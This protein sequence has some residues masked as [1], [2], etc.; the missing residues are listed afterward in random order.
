[1]KCLLR[2]MI[3]GQRWIAILAVS[4]VLLPAGA[5]RAQQVIGAAQS[6]F[7]SVIY[8][9]A[10]TDL[11]GG[12]AWN[13]AD[14]SRQTAVMQGNAALDLQVATALFDVSRLQWVITRDRMWMGGVNYTLYPDTNA[15]PDPT[16]AQFKTVACTVNGVAA[17]YDSAAN[18]L[19]AV[20]CDLE[21]NAA[22]AQSV[23]NEV[24][25]ISSATASAAFNA[26]IV[27]ARTAAAKLLTD[28][29]K[30]EAAV[31]PAGTALAN[32]GALMLTSLYYLADAQYNSGA[33]GCSVSLPA[34][35]K[36]GAASQRIYCGH[37]I[38][39]LAQEFVFNGN[40]T[41]L[42]TEDRVFNIIQNE[43]FEN[44]YL[45]TVENECLIAKSTETPGASWTYLLEPSDKT[46]YRFGT[47]D[48][49]TAYA[50]TAEAAPELFLIYTAEFIHRSWAST[51]EAAFVILEMMGD[52]PV[53][54]GDTLPN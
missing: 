29:P 30:A 36:S 54:T 38:A 52:A 45:G 48:N 28:W 49:Q 39:N 6:N 17:T 50:E 37:A 22:L 2:W 11:N 9:G 5:V 33:A 34:V 21:T 19:Q 25:G 10:E 31:P 44:D 12:V 4:A 7:E 26:Y 32:P 43:I 24:N 53:V 20:A 15:S 42:Y 13:L 35:Q 47:N 1:M 41:G 16:F 27:A 18:P 40:F 46:P 51:D 14:A 8:S 3:T 23:A